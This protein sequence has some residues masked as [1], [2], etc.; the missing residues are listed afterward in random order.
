MTI[1]F[2]PGQPLRKRKASIYYIRVYLHVLSHRN[3]ES[4]SNTTIKEPSQV[5]STLRNPLNKSCR[6]LKQQN[7]EMLNRP[8][9]LQLPPIPKPNHIL[10]PTLPH[11]SLPHETLNLSP[12]PRQQIISHRIRRKRE[13]GP[14]DEVDDP[15][16]KAV[17]PII[18]KDFPVVYSLAALSALEISVYQQHE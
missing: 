6:R 4:S 1:T 14:D 11:E 3:A 2:T 7:M 18:R 10:L 9:A 15:R 13:L 5:K 12:T 8:H 17:G 16:V